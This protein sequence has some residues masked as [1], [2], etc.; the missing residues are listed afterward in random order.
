M[1]GEMKNLNQFAF[2]KEHAASVLKK[3]REYNDYGYG[4]YSQGT[5]GY[6]WP[7]DN[8]IIEA[9]ERFG[10]QDY[11]LMY[12]FENSNNYKLAIKC[13]DSKLEE[14]LNASDLN[15]NEVNRFR[16]N[17]NGADKTQDS[18]F[19][20]FPAMR[21]SVLT[22]LDEPEPRMKET[23]PFKIISFREID[24][25]KLDSENDSDNKLEIKDYARKVFAKLDKNQDV[26]YSLYQQGKRNLETVFSTLAIDA[27]FYLPWEKNFYLFSITRFEPTRY[28]VRCSYEK[29]DEFLGVID[30]DLDWIEGFKKNIEL[31]SQAKRFGQ[32]VYPPIVVT[33]KAVLSQP[34]DWFK[35]T[36]PFEVL[37]FSPWL[38][39]EL[40]YT[41]ESTLDPI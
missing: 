20:I 4:W 26:G 29:K 36:V 30:R 24:K 21:I 3:I 38:L 17:L 25:A 37:S 41:D 22:R 11:F 12:H 40:G 16:T 13:P 32:P 2:Q 5:T 31:E 15:P 9:M 35:D 19:P 27:I 8:L 34:I 18:F 1:D 33:V 28:C 39:K 6:D 14:F 10:N 7:F 23:V